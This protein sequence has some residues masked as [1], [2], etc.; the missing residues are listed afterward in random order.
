VI[1]SLADHDPDVDGIYRLT[2]PLPFTFPP[3]SDVLR[4]GRRLAPSPTVTDPLPAAAS[5]RSPRP[6]AAVPSEGG[7]R[8]LALE[9]ESDLDA[10]GARPAAKEVREVKDGRRLGMMEDG[11]R[12]ALGKMGSAK[13]GGKM[14]GGKMAGGKMAAARKSLQKSLQR[15][16]EAVVVTLRPGTMMPYNAQATATC[17]CTCAC[18]CAWTCTCSL[19]A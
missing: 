18:A 14:A 4:N 1:Q 3:V 9:P 11:R 10:H 2:Q 16:E 7:D 8:R 6:T 17:A 5:S 12:K 19:E 13:M 15:T